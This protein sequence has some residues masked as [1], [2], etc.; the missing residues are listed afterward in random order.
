MK[1]FILKQS[2]QLKDAKMVSEN[3]KLVSKKGE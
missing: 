2:K 1:S 3:L